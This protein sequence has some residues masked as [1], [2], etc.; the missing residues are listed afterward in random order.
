MIASIFP[1][2]LKF[3]EVISIFTFCPIFISF[4]FDSEISVFIK[5]LYKSVKI[6]A[7]ILGIAI[8]PTLI[9]F[10][11]INPSFGAFIFK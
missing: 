3:C 10:F 11:M 2:V 4:K 1:S 8:S 9:D 5:R 7:G 6:K